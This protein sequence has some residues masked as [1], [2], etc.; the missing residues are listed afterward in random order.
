MKNRVSASVVLFIIIMIFSFHCT[1]NRAGDGFICRLPQSIKRTWIG[2]EFWT[3]P[4]QDWQL[5]EGRIECIS[6][7]GDRNVFLL[8]HELAEREGSFKM[9][10]L[11]G[12]LTDSNISAETGWVGFKVGIR[13]EFDDY[14]DN[15]VRGEGFRLGFTTDGR[16]FIGALNVSQ[17]LTGSIRDSLR[18][19]MMA[20]PENKKYGITLRAYNAEGELQGEIQKTDIDP[21][22]M[23]GGVAL[24]C[25]HG[26]VKNTPDVRPVIDD[27]NWGN[28]AG[29]DRG[30]DVKVWFSDWTLSGNKVQHFPERAWGPILFAQHTLSKG[31][32]KITAQMA[33]LGHDAQTVQLEVQSANGKWM[34]AG[35]APIDGLSRTATI[36]VEK[37]NDERNVPYRLVYSPYQHDVPI[38][39]F[40]M[41]VI[42]KNPTEKDEIVVAGFT[43]NNDLGFPN[44]DIVEQL[45][46]HDPDFLFF[47]G[48]QLYEGVGGFGVQRSPVDK[49]CLD[50]LRK[51]M[52][53]GWAYGD[54]MRDRPT[55]SIP[56]DHDVYHGNIWG[57]GGIA[58]PKGLSGYRA[59]DPGGYKMPP[60]WVN[61]VQRTQTSHLPD[62]PDPEPVAQGIGVYFCD[63]QYGGISFA[64]LEDRK[65]K[66][67]PS[68]LL[69]EAQVVNG[70]ATNREFDAKTQA[71]V[72]GAVLLGE[73]QLQF[74]D[75]WASDWSNGTWMKVALSQTIFANVATL[76]RED[77]YS[78]EKVP[79]LRILREGEYPPDDIPVSDMDSNGWPQT[80]RKKA[81]RALRKG[82]A[83]H[84][85]G[86]QHLGSTIHYGIG[87]FKDAG[88]AFCVPAI[89]N[90]WPR[91]W[92]PIDPGKNRIPG[93]PKYTG[94]F[95]DGF[96]NKMT[97][98]AISN[99]I[100]TG[101]KPSRLYDRATGYGIV[102]FNRSDRKI[103]MECWPRTSNPK[104]TGNGQYPGWPVVIHQ[105]DNSYCQAEHYLPV[106]E[107]QGL[108]DPVIQVIEEATGELI[109]SLRIQGKA[110]KPM[111]PRSGLYTVKVGDPD[112]I[113]MKIIEHLNTDN[114]NGDK[115]QIS[116]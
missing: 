21:D 82:F 96:G 39:Q 16:L 51:W 98:H 36:R 22:W 85:A 104:K 83:F 34:I 79:Q 20:T 42:R 12:P 61:M 64:V 56:D 84:I 69:P 53:Y 92:L 15:A 44:N 107:I 37:W 68:P 66:S 113:P 99:P 24:V 45:W 108:D 70:W 111:V 13:G 48:D 105:T 102:R 100:Y 89:S 17:A 26:S 54:L 59:Q 28:R 6:S 112:E 49:A 72:K 116:F 97:I 43:G 78:D 90:V 29:T 18:L 9:E 74:L 55:V 23:E 106:V 50:Y 80:G 62:P 46:H 109:Y 35:E 67:A 3:N 31:L 52:I 93:S 57:A 4:L 8:T 75:S 65:F 87:A 27:G 41:G 71:D 2:P 7:G 10:V 5:N 115:V 103:V 58:A 1:S 40:F 86:D 95:E 110:F 101:L 81:L 63:I 114:S 11:L 25:S 30:G 33:P 14:R 77:A 19:S 73:R 91:R 38:Q 76:P 32:L 88:F 94:D 47:S 60:E